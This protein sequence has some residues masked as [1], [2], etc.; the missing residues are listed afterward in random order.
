MSRLVGEMVIFGMNKLRV[1][2]N[3]TM[4]TSQ[5]ESVIMIP[6]RKTGM[7]K[8][9]IPE[10]M[11]VGTIK[12]GIERPIEIVINEDVVRTRLAF[13]IASGLMMPYRFIHSRS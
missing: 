11:D 9:K 10:I 7:G 2:P 5:T 13:V 4:K 12:P 8:S 1:L 6:H 3:N